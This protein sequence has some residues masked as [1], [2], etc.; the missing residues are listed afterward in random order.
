MVID[1]ADAD[2]T[3]FPDL[4]VIGAAADGIPEALAELERRLA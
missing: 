2:W 1:P 3:T 4:V